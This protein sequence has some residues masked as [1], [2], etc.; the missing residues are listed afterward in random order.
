MLN[1][2]DNIYYVDFP[3]INE[4][5]VDIDIKNEWHRQKEKWGKQPHTLLEWHLIL[6][7]EF[8]EFSKAINEG[9]IDE[10]YDELIQVLAVAKKIACSI[11]KEDV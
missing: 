4:K 7:K 10:I 3:I 5:K 9:K 1:K 8:G 6:S 11:A 2:L